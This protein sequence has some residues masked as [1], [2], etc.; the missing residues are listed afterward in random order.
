MFIAGGA[1]ENRASLEQLSD[2]ELAAFKLIGSSRLVL[3][4]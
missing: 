2:C 1:I 3:C 4:T